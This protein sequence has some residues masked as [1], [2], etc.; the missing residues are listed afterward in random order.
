M[1]VIFCNFKR[2]FT[3][4]PQQAHRIG[5]YFPHMGNFVRYQAGQEQ[6]RGAKDEKIDHRAQKC[7]QK[8][9]KA[10]FP[11]PGGHDKEEQRRGDRQPEQQVQKRAQQREAHPPARKAEKVI[12]KS[13]THSKHGRTQKY[14]KLAG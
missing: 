2:F 14:G 8:H 9:K 10:H 11:R 4:E 13:A 6:R 3:Q 7:G 1:E 12:E 5:Q